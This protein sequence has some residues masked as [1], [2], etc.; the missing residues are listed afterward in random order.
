MEIKK[1]GILLPCMVAIIVLI[2]RGRNLPNIVGILHGPHSCG[3][4]AL[5]I[6]KLIED[7]STIDIPLNRS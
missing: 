7:H 5:I 2:R 6:C 3:T 4:S 1:R